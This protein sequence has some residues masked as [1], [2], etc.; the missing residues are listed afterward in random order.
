[1]DKQVVQHLP[2]F[3]FS[4]GISAQFALAISV[5]S[6][7]HDEAE[8]TPHVLFFSSVIM[9][10]TASG[11]CKQ[12]HL[13]AGHCLLLESWLGCLHHPPSAISHHEKNKL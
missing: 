2:A 1:M 5:Q 9:Y 7:V 3:V 6:I 10:R 4:I 8:S 13:L 11:P 12:A